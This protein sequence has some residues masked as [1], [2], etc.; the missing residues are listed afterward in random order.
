MKKW[1]FVKIL[2]F[3]TR[4]AC[5]HSLLLFLWN[6]ALDWVRILARFAHLQLLLKD[7]KKEDPYIPSLLQKRTSSEADLYLQGDQMPPPD[8]RTTASLRFP[9]I[10]VLRN[11][12]VVRE[13]GA[14]PLRLVVRAHR[15]KFLKNVPRCRLMALLMVSSPCFRCF[16]VSNYALNFYSFIFS[17]LPLRE[18]KNRRDLYSV[19]QVP[20]W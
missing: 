13:T 16:L 8:P 10:N 5:F 17:F 15:I 7:M 9:K 12:I 19:V 2:V 4:S 3:I 6:L 14:D 20:R 1:V 18:R 11:P